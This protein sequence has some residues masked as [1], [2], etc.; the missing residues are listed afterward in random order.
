LVVR[1]PQG[2][3]AAETLFAQAMKLWQGP[4]FGHLD[5]PWLNGAREDLHRRRLAVELDRSDLALRR[6]RHAS[7]LSALLDTAA[8]HPLDERLA[9]QLLLTLYRCGRQADALAQYQGGDR[10][11]FERGRQASSLVP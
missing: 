6:G 4:A 9:G 10:N 5:T 11:T 8:Q 1:R 3:D 2:D 7:L